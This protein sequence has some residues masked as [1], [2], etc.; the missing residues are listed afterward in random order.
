MKAPKVTNY[1]DV[2]TGEKIV[3]ILKWHILRTLDYSKIESTT[4]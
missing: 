4:H 3:K 1:I 2:R